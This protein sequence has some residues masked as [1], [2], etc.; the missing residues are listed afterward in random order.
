MNIES[1][2]VDRSNCGVLDIKFKSS[3]NIRCGDVV[4]IE[5]HGETKYFKV[6]KV[7]AVSSTMLS[8]LSCEAVGFGYG[9]DVIEELDLKDIRELINL[10]VTKIDDNDK[11]KELSR[12]NKYC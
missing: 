6:N 4:S 9:S 11:I 5:V 2:S 12:R 3:K 8:C 10:K 7:E 1:V